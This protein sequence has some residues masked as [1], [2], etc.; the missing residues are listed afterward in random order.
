MPSALEGYHVMEQPRYAPYR[1][2]Q[3]AED[4]TTGIPDSSS[5][6]KNQRSGSRAAVHDAQG[7]H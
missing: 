7:T 2:L 6:Q 5:N 1:A 3:Q 4:V